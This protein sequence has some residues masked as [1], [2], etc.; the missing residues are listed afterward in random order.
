MDNTYK[1][2][3]Q[4]LHLWIHDMEATL[5]R[6]LQFVITSEAVNGTRQLINAIASCIQKDYPFY[7]NE[8]YVIADVLFLQAPNP[9][10]PIALNS[11]AYGELVLIEK[12]LRLEPINMQFWNY[13]HPRICK[14]SRSLYADGHFS[15]AAKNAMIEVET[16]LRELFRELKPNATEPP[17]IGE[18]IGA[19][20]TEN[21]VYHFVDTATTSGK[22]YRRGI[23]AMFEGAFAAYRNPALHKNLNS[24][25]QRTIEQIVLAS[26]LMYVLDNDSKLASI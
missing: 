20:L 5:Q 24:S 21:G 8:L 14:V 15:S 1:S 12:H 6:G 17:K 19:L 3:L 7:A 22:D 18:I 16:R 10:V 11:T 4:S 2:Y 13:I 26:Q 23:Q 25:Q 9:L